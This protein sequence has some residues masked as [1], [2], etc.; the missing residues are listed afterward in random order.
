M[1]KRELLQSI[2]FGQ[3]VAEEEEDELSSYFV[4]TEQWRRIY[5]GEVD[6]VY[7]AK[8]AGK[9]AIYS[10]LLKRANS[11]Y[12]RGIL[13]TPAENPRGATVFKNIVADP[14]VTEREFISLWKLYF[15]SLIG[16]IIQEHN[17]S[18]ESATKVIDAL[19]GAQL[20]PKEKSLK[21]LLQN[22][23][24]YI[25]NL[26]KIESAETGIAIDPTA[27]QPSSW[28]A[29]ITIREPK[30][31]E[32]QGGLISI[33]DLLDLAN[34][35]LDK[36]NKSVWL[37]L[38]RLDVAFADS[39]D[40]ENNALRA[41]FRVYNDFTT[42]KRISLKIFLRTDIW[43]RI[44][45]EGFREASHITKYDTISWDNHTTLL[46]LVVR[47]ALTNV[48]L[49]EFYDVDEKIILQDTLLQEK[50]FYRIFPDKVNIGAKQATT[51]NW[52]LSRTRDGSKK[53]APRELIHLLSA[54]K[55]AQLRSLDVGG[56]EPPHESLF[57]RSAL[58]GGLPEVSKAR[59][60]QTI[61]AEYPLLKTWIAKLQGAKTEHTP[62]TLAHIWEVDIDKANQIADKLHKIG[63][64][65]QR[66]KK[67]INTLWVPFL[68][69]GA[70][71]MVQGSA[72]P[73]QE[74]DY[75]EEDED[76]S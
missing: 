30:P 25:R 75:V 53:T 26:S 32:R 33:D 44:T 65:E 47:R 41:L 3:R 22:V 1:S 12:E 43:K 15:L 57:D 8:G 7:G 60:E 11:L 29:K 5:I 52:M 64:F 63:F 46:N 67:G 55:N 24:E 21:N 40:L 58:V 59:L 19:Q 73:G 28:T 10:Y 42:Y 36:A 18:G 35:A 76:E 37:A 56:G 50:L 31:A 54:A 27:V 70:L 17:I 61:Y 9:S 6:I 16:R 39:P 13:I 71:S 48:Q 69:R 38:D 45:D 20:L 68:Y 74:D 49:R 34:D 2:T 51:F 4:E 14:P 62:E 66:P 23:V 72:I